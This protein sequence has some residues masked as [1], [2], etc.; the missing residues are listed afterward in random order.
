MSDGEYALI[1]V[2]SILTL[3]FAYRR[4]ITRADKTH[5][6]CMHCL[7]V[8]EAMDGGA[9]MTVNGTGTKLVTE[10]AKCPECG[11]LEASIKYTAAWISVAQNKDSYRVLFV[12]GS[13]YL[14]R[15]LK[16]SSRSASRRE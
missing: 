12:G 13:R 9:T 3:S 7:A 5:Q 2:V 8:T 10:G 15:R 6:F 11:S 14:I 4:F 16:R 1:F